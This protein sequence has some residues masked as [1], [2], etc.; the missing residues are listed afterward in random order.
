MH[1]PSKSTVLHHILT[2]PSPDLKDVVFQHAII[3]QCF[4]PVRSLPKDQLSYEVRNGNALLAIDAGRLLD[5]YTHERCTMEVPAG[6]KARLLFAYINDKAIRTGDPVIEMGESLREFMRLSGIPIGGKNGQEITRQV[7]NIAAADIL[8]GAWGSDYSTEDRTK[9]ARGVSFWMERDG[10][11]AALWQPTLR[12]SNDYME[13]LQNHRVPLDF[14]VLVALQDTPRL[15]DVYSWLA[16]RLP[17]VKRLA[18][19]RIPWSE[20]HRVFMHG[21]GRL[22]DFQRAFRR[23]VFA[24]SEYYPEARLDLTAEPNC[25]LLLPSRP[26]VPRQGLISLPG[27]ALFPRT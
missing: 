17:L 5:P 19:D 20:L 12:L 4:L 23:W 6:P 3:V 15:M 25:V 24:V 21:H 8:I 26:A 18:G 1:V 7:H 9:V 14:R 27:H 2:R 10:H 16:Y 11:Q 13:K 22:R